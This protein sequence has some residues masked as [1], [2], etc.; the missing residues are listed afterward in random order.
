MNE[1]VTRGDGEVVVFVVSVRDTHEAGTSSFSS[2]L[3]F[4]FRGVVAI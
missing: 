1:D 2:F 4:L 3:F